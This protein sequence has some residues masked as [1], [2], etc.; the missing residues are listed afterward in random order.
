MAPCCTSP[1]HPCTPTPRPSPHRRRP[2]RSPRSPRAPH[3]RANPPPN[4]RRHPPHRPPS[5]IRRS[6]RS[7]TTSTSAPTPPFPA[8]PAARATASCTRPCAPSRP[9]HCAPSSTSKSATWAGTERAR[10]LRPETLFKPAKLEGY[11][12]ELHQQRTA[13]SAPSDPSAPSAPRQQT[14]NRPRTPDSDA[15]YSAA[16]TLYIPEPP[17]KR[18]PEAVVRP[19]F[20]AMY[21][22]LGV[23]PRRPD[24]TPPANTDGQSPGS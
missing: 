13:A 9:K 1:P 6:P 15:V 14:P 3:P 4:Q 19:H 7:S 20:D 8:P 18:A 12:S 23:R 11:L 24:P 5:T 16:H 21:R 17:P 2:P 10:Y 22:M